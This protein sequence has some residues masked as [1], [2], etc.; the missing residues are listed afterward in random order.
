MSSGRAA[1]LGLT[2]AQVTA[3]ST[4]AGLANPARLLTYYSEEPILLRFHLISPQPGKVKGG[5]ACFDR[6]A[7]TTVTT[8]ETFATRQTTV[9][10]KGA[11]G[12]WVYLG[13]HW[14]PGQEHM[15]IGVLNMR[16][17]RVTHRIPLEDC[18]DAVVNATAYED[19]DI[20]DLANAPGGGK[21]AYNA[22]AGSPAYT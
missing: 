17:K 5:T 20:Y 14:K 6:T 21:G 13:G 8:P 10:N 4:T 22:D 9:D 2:S 7:C 19:C 16:N 11:S 18:G 3:A 15:Y 1:A 12:A